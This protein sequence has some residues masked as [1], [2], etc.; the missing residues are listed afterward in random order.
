M[1]KKLYIILILLSF[2]FSS[3]SVSAQSLKVAVFNFPPFFQDDGKGGVEGIMANYL[4]LGLEKAGYS[5]KIRIVPVGRVY[6]YLA[7]GNID[8]TLG[9]KGVPILKGKVLIGENVVSSIRMSIF[10]MKGT[11][12]ISSP[13]QLNGKSLIVRRGASYGGFIRYLKNPANK[14]KLMYTSSEKSALKMLKVGR[15]DYL[16]NYDRVIE[17]ASHATGI[18]GIQRYP[19][20]KID[21]YIIVSKKA[22]NAEK[23]FNKL[24]TAMQQLKLEGKI[25]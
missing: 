8:L 4:K 13:K 9:V 20:K 15:A 19:L 18:S 2:V 23:I 7:E 1:T 11:P 5:Y 3:V 6:K 22:P 10:A 25:K 16:L 17:A 24:D 21:G 14:I 12:A